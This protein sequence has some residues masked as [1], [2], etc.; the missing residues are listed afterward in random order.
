M[1]FNKIAPFGKEDTAKDLQD[2]A[3]KTQDTLVPLP[4]S[5]QQAGAPRAV[6]D[7]M[8]HS[9]HTGARVGTPKKNRSKTDSLA[10][11]K[12]RKA[13]STEEEQ[14]QPTPP[15][16][17]NLW[18]SQIWDYDAEQQQGVVYEEDVFGE[19]DDG[20]G[21]GEQQQATPEKMTTSPNTPSTVPPIGSRGGN[22][23]EESKREKD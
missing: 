16:W 1:N 11:P 12:K 20:E 6:I 9:G 4:S 15:V 2:H 17:K 23:K 19:E 14:Q 5:P 8:H 22:L 21:A 18:D 10:T 3:A 13:D 7:R